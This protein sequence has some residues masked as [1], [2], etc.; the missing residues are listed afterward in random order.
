VV[1]Q[2]EKDKPTFFIQ[3]SAEL[4]SDLIVAFCDPTSKNI[5]FAIIMNE[6]EIY[7]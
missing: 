7:L 1:E 2:L 3:W 4:N 6:K 5:T